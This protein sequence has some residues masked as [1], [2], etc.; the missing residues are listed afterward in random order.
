MKTY[1]APNQ[2][3][4]VGKAWEIRHQLREMR[5]NNKKQDT[6]QGYLNHRMSYSPSNK[7]K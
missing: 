3:H 6:V 4:M 1:I 5:K 7:S 2:I